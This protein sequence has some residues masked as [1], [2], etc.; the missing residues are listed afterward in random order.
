MT[1]ARWSDPVSGLWT[2]RDA[3]W[4]S[5]QD[6]ESNVFL[7]SDKLMPH[8][9]ALPAILECPGYLPVPCCC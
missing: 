3:E 2:L 9:R 5:L 6:S 8:S 7:T 4:L 1:F